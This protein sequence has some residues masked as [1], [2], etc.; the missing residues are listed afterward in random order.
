MWRSIFT[1]PLPNQ[2]DR[3]Y[4]GGGEFQLRR[5]NRVLTTTY[6]ADA[7]ENVSYTYDQTGHGF[8]VG[9]LTGVKDADGT[10][11]R[12]YD[13]RGNI[14]TEKRVTGNVAL[15]TSIAYDAASRVSAIT[16]PSGTAVTYIRDAAGQVAGI[17]AKPRGAKTA[18]P[19]VT[20]VT[21]LP[22]AP[23]RR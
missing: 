10:L 20:G 9:R 16:Y 17:T 21:H 7:A 4:R 22:S 23:P 13:E 15:T 19:V 11:S 1:I 3:R 2:E 6:P 14:V 5:V 12:S 18:T 8:G